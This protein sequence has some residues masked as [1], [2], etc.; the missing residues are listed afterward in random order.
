[1]H[2][3]HYFLPRNKHTQAH[4]ALDESVGLRYNSARAEAARRTGGP[5]PPV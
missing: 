4:H 2:A 5:D 1:M 3:Q